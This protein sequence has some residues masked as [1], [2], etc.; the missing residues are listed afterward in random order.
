MT[1]VALKKHHTVAEVSALWR[2][3]RLFSDLPGALRL[4]NTSNIKEA[5]RYITLSIPLSIV[6]AQ[7]AKLA[8]GSK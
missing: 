5:R 7:H 2:V 4:G 3:R 6:E 1:D 8:G